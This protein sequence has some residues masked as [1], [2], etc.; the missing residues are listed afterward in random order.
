[1]SKRRRREELYVAKMA[2][3]VAGKAVIAGEV[4]CPV[5][6]RWDYMLFGENTRWTYRFNGEPMECG[7]DGCDRKFAHMG[8]LHRHREQV[9]GPEWDERRR[10]AAEAR[11]WAQKA[12]AEGETVGGIPVVERRGSPHGKVD[13][14]DIQDAMARGVNR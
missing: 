7:T 4:I 5:G 2:M 6:E 12:E 11:H 3:T 13:Y 1:M 10:A 9:H 8:A 14:L